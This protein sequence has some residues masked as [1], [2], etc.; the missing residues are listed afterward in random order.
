MYLQHVADQQC[1]TFQTLSSC[2]LKISS[3]THSLIFQE[4]KTELLRPWSA[5]RLANKVICEGSPTVSVPLVMSQISSVIESTDFFFSSFCFVFWL[6]PDNELHYQF[7]QRRFR[8]PLPT[9]KNK[10]WMF[11]NKRSKHFF[12][13]LLLTSKVKTSRTR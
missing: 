5:C 10:E 13:D 7:S 6:A 1:P 9:P 12:K 3:W 8:Y 4:L 2:L 11:K